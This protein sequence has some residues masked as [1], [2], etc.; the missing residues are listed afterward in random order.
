[1]QQAPS[2]GS[3]LSGMPCAEALLGRLS[4]LVN[5]VAHGDWSRHRLAIRQ[6]HA[7]NA[8]ATLTWWQKKAQ[9]K[10][11]SLHGCPNGQGH[12]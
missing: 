3:Q 8:G 4:R 6:L 12:A 10:P 7:A 11:C 1:M 2:S 9:H 5:L